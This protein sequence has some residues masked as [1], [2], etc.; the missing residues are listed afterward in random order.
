MVKKIVKIDQYLTQLWTKCSSL[1]FWPTLYIITLL[2][3]LG[4]EREVS[5]EP[6]LFEWL[7]WYLAGVP[8]FMTAQEFHDAGLP[9][10]LTYSPVWQFSRYNIQETTEQ[11]YDRCY[12]VTRDILKRHE[13]EGTCSVYYIHWLCV[14]S[15]FCCC[16]SRCEFG[17]RRASSLQKFAVAFLTYDFYRARFV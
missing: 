15:L 3:G 17:Y 10:C 7:G 4:V 5:L 1:L 6:G 11:F 9:V 13:S 2:T 14:I 16:N 8:K 12:Q